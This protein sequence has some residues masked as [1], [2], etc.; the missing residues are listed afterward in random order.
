MAI[1]VALLSLL[2]APVAVGQS[3]Y[4]PLLETLALRIEE[5]MKREQVPGAAV[6]IV[7]RDAVLLPEVTGALSPRLSLRPAKAA[8]SGKPAMVERRI[9]D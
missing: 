1:R 2:L 5:M 9:S 6:A 8:S 4:A 7:A 3:R